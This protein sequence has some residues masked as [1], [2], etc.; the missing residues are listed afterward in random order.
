[1]AGS[2]CSGGFCKF[3]E[4]G[5]REAPAGSAAGVLL[6]LLLALEGM[7]GRQNE[8]GAGSNGSLLDGCFHHIRRQAII[9][10]DR[11]GQI[12]TRQHCDYVPIRRDCNGW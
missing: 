5:G 7:D 4:G 11:D 9:V 1:M 6:S 3:H 12:V 8:V 10:F 2:G